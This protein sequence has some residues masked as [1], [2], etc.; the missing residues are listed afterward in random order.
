MKMAS[1]LPSIILLVSCASAKEKLYVGSTP[2]HAV[3][4]SFLG[5]SLSDSIDF[6][7]WRLTAKDDQYSLH[8]Q[9][10]IGKPNT[11]GFINDGK[12]I[13]L[14]GELRKENNYY[15]IQNGHR[16]LKLLAL[17]DNLLHFLNNDNSLLVGNGGWSYTINADN[18]S[19]TDR[20][21]IV[22]KQTSLRDSAA[23]E[24]R[25]PCTNFPGTHPSPNCVK[26]KWLVVLYANSKTNEP[27]TYHLN[28][29]YKRQG[30]IKGTWKTITGKGGRMIYQLM[31][32]KE[33]ESIYL[34]KL[35]EDILV[36]TDNQGKLLVG[37]KN[38][39]YTLNKRW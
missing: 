4:R 17:N 1:L 23:F 26:M 8:C 5:I 38:F 25:T 11:D 37:D 30:G 22:S 29:N 7:K 18:P 35:S 16:T 34:L 28:G 12:T 9:F 36:F 2:A 21:N 24:G 31:V 20:V 6:I 10:G 14:S 19:P 32:E 33:N 3:I 13:D 27:T 15:F 39:S